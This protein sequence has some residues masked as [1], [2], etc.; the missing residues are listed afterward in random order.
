M[1][2]KIDR[3]HIERL[4]WLFTLV[5]FVSYVSRQG[6]GT[7]LVEVI[8]S[9]FAPK[10]TAALALTV[11]SI[12]Y[13]SGQ[14]ISGYLSD[15][16]KPQH[17]MLSGLLI[18]SIINLSVFFMKDSSFLVPAW[19]INGFAQ[20]LMWPPLVR[21][22]SAS[23]DDTDYQK[24]CIR[25]SQGA[26]V[27]TIV[28]YLIAPLIIS[29]LNF[30]FVFLFSGM[31]ALVVAVLWHKGFPILSKKVVK[32]EKASE[33]KMVVETGTARFDKT[34][35][36]VTIFIM[37][38]IVMQGALRDGVTS[39]TPTLLSET[40]NLSSS[41]S[42]LS[43]VVLPLFAIATHSFVGWIYKNFQ[44]NPLVCAAVIFAVGTL[45]A[46]L[47]LLVNGK[48]PILAVLF[49][50]VLVGCMHGVNLI[51]ITM[52][53]ASYKK[54]GHVALI[55]GVLNSATYIGAAVSTYGVVV[56]AEAFGWNS[57]I[58]L[59]AGI[60]AVGGLICIGLLKLWKKFVS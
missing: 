17:V 46:I 57:T 6:L 40:F 12:T 9:G 47:L 30:K 10:T 37:L 26:N 13:G 2:N 4:I 22:M 45:S 5:Y 23:F 32:T 21:L 38:A 35:L 50:A 31:I 36:I 7:I 54:Y 28:L 20:A 43:G 41:V 27:G 29:L 8:K 16:F 44:K 14:I 39:W 59:W 11:C 18:T 49:L 42:I 53:P 25:V 24:S 3:K 48:S 33:P 58:L 1:I 19:G 15:R 60:A 55:A 34:A 51:L 52:V 56:Y